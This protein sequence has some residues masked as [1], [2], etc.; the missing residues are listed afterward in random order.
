VSQG[1]NIPT[2]FVTFGQDPEPD[3]RPHTSVKGSVLRAEHLGSPEAIAKAFN[4][5]RAELARVT[6]AARI[7]PLMQANLI[8]RISFTSGTA[9]N[10]E[11]GLGRIWSEFAVIGQFTA[12]LGAR[13]VYIDD[14]HAKSYLRLVPDA[15]GTASVLVW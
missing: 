15:T 8:R 14:V 10:I 7:S 4:D 6:L 2:T 12:A 3:S 9:V 1:R 5:L 11:H 13:A